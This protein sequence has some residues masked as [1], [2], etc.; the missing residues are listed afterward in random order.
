VRERLVK[1]LYYYVAMVAVLLVVRVATSGSEAEL[2]DLS[3]RA[4]ELTAEGSQLRRQIS[5]LESPA[6]VREWAVQNR[7]KPFS[8]VTVEDAKLEGLQPVKEE[9]VPA[10]K[11]EV[12]TQWR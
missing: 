5:G 3:Q 6:R 9:P 7:M 8:A 1:Y 12:T 4:D 10:R 11:L 2:R